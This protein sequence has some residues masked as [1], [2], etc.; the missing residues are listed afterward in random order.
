LATF[1]RNVFAYFRLAD[2]FDIV[3]ISVILYFILTWIKQRA[4]RS[5]VIALISVVLLYTCAR[6]F[7][8]YLTSMLFQAGLTAALVAL[9]LIFQNDLRMAIE[10]LSS[11]G[12]YRSKHSLV[13]SSKTIDSLVE[14][15]VN[16]ARDRI[17]ALVVIKGRDSL[18]RHLSGGIALSGRLS[19][20]LLYSIFHPSTPS[21]DGAVIIEADR[22]EYFGVRLPLSH[23][24]LEVGS[25]GTRHTAGLGMSERSD[26]L[27]IIVSEERGII[28]I[29]ENGR[30][31]QVAP[32]KFRTR[33][34]HFY[35]T[36][37]PDPV[38]NKRHT[39][40]TGNLPLKLASLGFAGLFWM[41]LAFKIDTINRTFTI[42]VE[43]R[44]IPEY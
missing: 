5:A 11:W 33:L 7:S 39:W 9:V 21:H 4:S 36:I 40:I 32:D 37:F 1:F 12:S 38:K 31:D 8:M 10:H 17:G 30:L 18:D 13:A 24:S 34:E 14:A 25:A 27:V 44:N 41:M 35:R 15:S 26:A 23:N 6:V 43:C 28:N 2:L 20:P 3:I 16:L 19:V 22:I 42:P 29:A